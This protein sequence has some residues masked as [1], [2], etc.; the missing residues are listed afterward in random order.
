VSCWS[1]IATLPTVQNGVRSYSVVSLPSDPGPGQG[2]FESS[3]PNHVY[4]I[5]MGFSNRSVAATVLFR[6][7]VGT[8]GV[9]FLPIKDSSVHKF[10]LPSG[11]K[12]SVSSYQV[13]EDYWT[14]AAFNGT[15]TILYNV[16]MTGT[17]SSRHVGK[18]VPIDIVSDWVNMYL[19]HTTS[20]H[21]CNN[22]S[23]PTPVYPRVSASTLSEIDT[24]TPS[25]TSWGTISYPHCVQHS[26]ISTVQTETFPYHY[27][28]YVR[29]DYGTGTDDFNNG[30]G[31]FGIGTS[32][33]RHYVANITYF[34]TG[35]ATA[36]VS[37]C[38]FNWAA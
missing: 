5:N 9:S 23:L 10:A 14:V 36:P 12:V 2:M 6:S 25:L 3:S 4:Q 8:Y 7:A 35:Q 11:Y 15:D 18:I 13:Y 17:V 1:Y 22:S 28:F 33:S 20:D 34:G 16:Y 38:P 29:S 31:N 37:L 21:V 24:P 32:P 19:V 30:F 26:T 27:V